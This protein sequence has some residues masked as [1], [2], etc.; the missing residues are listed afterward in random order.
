M[1][2]SCRPGVRDNERLQ[3]MEQKAMTKWQSVACRLHV[4]SGPNKG[5]QTVGSG[6]LQNIISSQPGY[7]ELCPSRIMSMQ[8]QEEQV[9]S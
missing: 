2:A 9:G 1:V 5:V 7:L 3:W 8:R 6:F 4:D